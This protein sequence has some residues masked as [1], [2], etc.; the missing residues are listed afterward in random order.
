MNVVLAL[1]GTMVFVAA[2]GGGDDADRN[3]RACGGVPTIGALA[4]GAPIST[5]GKCGGPASVDET[6]PPAELPD[7][8]AVEPPADLVGAERAAFERGR[9]LITRTGCLACHKIGEEGGEL[10]PD[11][12][13][14]GTRLS[15]RELARWLVDP[16]APMPTFKNLPDEDRADLVTFLAKLR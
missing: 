7:A 9:A 6:S 2:C 3:A 13:G 5:P 4:N 16:V 1:L 10:G 14:A 8:G 15:R 11:L 12:S